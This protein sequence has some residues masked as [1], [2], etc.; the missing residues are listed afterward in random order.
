MR[1]CADLIGRNSVRVV[2]TTIGPAGTVLRKRWLWGQMKYETLIKTGGEK[3]WKE[4]VQAYLACLAFVDDQVGKILK[5]LDESPYRD[6]TIVVL[7]GDNGYHVGEKDCITKWH[8][9]E[10]S[11]RVPLFIHMPNSKTNGQT[12]DHPVSLIDLYP[13]LVDL[14][15]LPKEPNKG[16][17]DISLDGYSLRPFLKDPARQDWDGPAVA[18]MGVRDLEGVKKYNSAYMKEAHF[19][20]RSKR[21]RYTLCADGEEEL[22]DHKNDPNEWT[23]LANNPKYDTIKNKLHNELISIRDRKHSS[24]KKGF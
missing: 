21:Y 4:W 12:C 22:Y 1:L 9:W 24:C 7:T 5:A 2:R 10:E 16:H 18:F 17:S 15:G 19:S 6:N 14:C 13:T 11:T 23:N 20:V 3:A 8:L